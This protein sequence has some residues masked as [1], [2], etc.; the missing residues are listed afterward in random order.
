MTP[1]ATRAARGEAENGSLMPTKRGEGAAKLIE[2]DA[3]FAEVEEELRDSGDI[4][5]MEKARTMV[6]DVRID[7]ENEESSPSA[8]IAA[9]EAQMKIAENHLAE[10]KNDAK[11][12]GWDSETVEYAGRQEGKVLAF[13]AVLKLLRSPPT[14]AVER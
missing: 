7:L 13:L 12:E 9:V 8:L 5:A 6:A 2:A 3:I 10:A 11:E 1:T 4:V 14:E